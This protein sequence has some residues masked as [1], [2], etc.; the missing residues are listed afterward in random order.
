M[1]TLLTQ[2]YIIYKDKTIDVKEPNLIS[3]LQNKLIDL[4]LEMLGLFQDKPEIL[5][6]E[7]NRFTGN[8]NKL[9]FYMIYNKKTKRFYLGNSIEF[10]KRVAYYNRDF[11]NYFG[12]KK[13]KLYNSFIEDIRINNCSETDFYFVPIMSFDKTTTEF[14]GLRFIE[15]KSWTFTKTEGALTGWGTRKVNFRVNNKL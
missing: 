13:N 9:G 15:D 12:N 14:S 1:K 6:Q 3:N 10:S 2:P 5:T 11:R 7:T 4:I 8:T